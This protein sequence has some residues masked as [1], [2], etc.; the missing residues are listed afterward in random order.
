MYKRQDSDSEPEPEESEP[1]ERPVTKS[2]FSC[3]CNDLIRGDEDTACTRCN[4]V[5]PNAAYDTE[6]WRVVIKPVGVSRKFIEP[7]AS[8]PIVGY[9][10][11]LKVFKFDGSVVGEF[12]LRNIDW[13]NATSSTGEFITIKYG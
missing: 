5:Y 2:C 8:K 6:T 13:A 7:V 10:D 4:A 9:R 11:T 12:D 3:R 1:F